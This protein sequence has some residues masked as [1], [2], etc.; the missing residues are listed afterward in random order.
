[1]AQSRLARAHKP[2]KSQGVYETLRRRIILGQL[3]PAEPIGEMQVASEL[4]CSQGPVR[5]A[6]LRLQEDGLVNRLGYRGT[7]VSAITQEEISE[8]LLLRKMIETRGVVYAFDGIDDAAMERLS[9]L[10]RQMENAAADD[11][12]FLL[13]ELDRAFHS[14]LFR[15]SGL[16]ALEPILQRCLL[17]VHRYKISLS[18]GDRTLIETAQGHWPIMQTLREKGLS[19][20]KR[21]IT[22]HIDTVCGGSVS[23]PSKARVRGRTVTDFHN[24]S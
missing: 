14:E 13:S 2:K 6:L 24:G 22:H 12:E 21:A 1:M 7:I 3:R 5:E 16:D 4:N 8:L 17:H 20:V 18:P 9:D 23:L 15:Y 10:V 19:E 11:D